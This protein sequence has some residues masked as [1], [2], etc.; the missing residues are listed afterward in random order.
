MTVE[1]VN[2]VLQTAPIVRANAEQTSTGDASGNPNRVQRVALAPYV[3]PYLT[4]DVHTNTPVLQIRDS[5]TGKVVDQIPSQ[6]NLQSKLDNAPA[7]ASQATPAESQVQ[8]QSQPQQSIPV[9]P[10]APQQNNAP[11]TAQQVA[12]FAAAAQAGNTNAGT[13]SLFA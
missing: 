10:P 5:N 7:P 9:A 12:A 1:A 13:V 2:S 3:S 6:L 4:V 11:A 8:A